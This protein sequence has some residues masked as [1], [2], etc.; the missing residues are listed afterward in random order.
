MRAMNESEQFVHDRLARI[1]AV[2]PDPFNYSAGAAAFFEELAK[3]CGHA[4]A[5]SRRAQALDRFVDHMKPKFND[6]AEG[7]NEG[8]CLTPRAKPAGEDK[9]PEEMPVE[10]HE[11]PSTPAPAGSTEAGPFA[12]WPGIQRFSDLLQEKAKP[13]IEPGPQYLTPEQL[14]DARDEMGL[15]QRGLGRLIGVPNWLISLLETGDKIATPPVYE[16]LRAALNIPMAP[17]QGDSNP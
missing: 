2:N 13:R 16:R 6:V 10:V 11:E 17:D 3:A 1:S 12:D 9:A 8:I 5:E 14:K 4:L 7:F 15:L